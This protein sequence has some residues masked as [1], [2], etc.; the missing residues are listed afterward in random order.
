[1][2]TRPMRFFL[3]FLGG[4]LPV[5][6]GGCASEGAG[7]I[8]T[9][10]A[11]AVGGA[12]S[13]INGAYQV[14]SGNR[15]R[16]RAQ[17]EALHARLDPICERKMAAIASRDPVADAQI[18]HRAGVVALL[19]SIPGLVVYPGLPHMKYEAGRV[20]QNPAAAKS[21]PLYQELEA[22]TNPRGEDLT[23]KPDEPQFYHSPAFSRFLEV[24]GAY[25]AAFNREIYRLATGESL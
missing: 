8:A 5:L 23:P 3:R 13:P 14:V 18:L 2:Q 6:I 12:L 24:E 9:A 15:E 22:L 10:S 7:G 1:M 11:V 16:K 19:P 21:S 25:K 4:I 20:A 17:F